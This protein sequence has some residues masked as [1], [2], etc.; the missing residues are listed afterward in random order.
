MNFASFSNPILS[1][2]NIH[3]GS[4]VCYLSVTI[5]LDKRV[6]L[7]IQAQ[8]FTLFSFWWRNYDV[9]IKQFF[10]F[11]FVPNTL[12]KM[13]NEEKSDAP[14]PSPGD[15]KLMSILLYTQL[16]VAQPFSRLHDQNSPFVC[17][18]FLNTLIPFLFKAQG[19]SFDQDVQMNLTLFIHI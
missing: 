9:L 15:I 19:K 5:S 8:L 1:L 3:F 12:R 11:C 2:L 17:E 6:S 4:I 13:E 18:K 7:I 10:L 16:V 14:P